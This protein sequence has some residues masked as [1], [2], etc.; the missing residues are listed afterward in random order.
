MHKLGKFFSLNCV[1]RCVWLRGVGAVRDEVSKIRS[2]Q[3]LL[4]H[5]GNQNVEYLMEDLKV[6][7]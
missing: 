2:L 5:A 7:L 3:S 6:C 1:I 4:S